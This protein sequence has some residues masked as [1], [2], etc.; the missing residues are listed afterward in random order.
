[1]H[2]GEIIRLGNINDLIEGKAK[3]PYCNYGIQHIWIDSETW[4]P[5]YKTIYDRSNNFWKLLIVTEIGWQSPEKKMQF[6]HV[7]DYIIIDA[8]RDHATITQMLHED[9]SMIFLQKMIRMI[10]P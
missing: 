7:G 9:K 2:P 10:S 8:R 5:L 4:E 3:D 1:M 6:T